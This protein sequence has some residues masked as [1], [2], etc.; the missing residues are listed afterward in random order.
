MAYTIILVDKIT[1]AQV[2]DLSDSEF[3]TLMEIYE[4]LRLVPENG[5]ILRKEAPQAAMY[6]F[7][8]RQIEVVYFIVASAVQVAIVRVNRLPD[9]G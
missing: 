5:L 8:H 9:V 2:D 1:E 6:A 3:A 4:V 7:V